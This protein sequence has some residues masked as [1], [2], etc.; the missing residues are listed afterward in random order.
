MNASITAMTLYRAGTLTLTQA[1]NRVGRTP[2]QLA[3]SMRSHGIAVRESDLRG[4][5]AV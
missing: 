2:T 4:D 3:S 1:A 5:D